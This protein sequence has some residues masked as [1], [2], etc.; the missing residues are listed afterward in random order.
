MYD[1]NRVTTVT[2]VTGVNKMTRVRYLSSYL[3]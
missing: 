1:W 3:E 2:S